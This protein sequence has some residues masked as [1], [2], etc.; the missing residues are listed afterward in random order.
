[1]VIKKIC[2]IGA[3]NE[4]NKTSTNRKTY[5]YK[6]IVVYHIKYIYM[7]KVFLIFYWVN[8]HLGP[9]KCTSMSGTSLA[10]RNETKTPQMCFPLVIVVQN[11]NCAL[12]L[13][14]CPF[15]FHFTGICGKRGYKET[16]LKWNKW[17]T[18]ASRTY[19]RK[20]NVI[21]PLKKLLFFQFL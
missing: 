1:M 15:F 13:L 10:R 9:W 2:K 8:P 14:I 6:I 20:K 19:K 4:N 5:S 18:S 3:D 16:G 11:V 21:F 12:T 7:A 17:K